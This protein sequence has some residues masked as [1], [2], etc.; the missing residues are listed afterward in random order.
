MIG[1]AQSE[2]V[3]PPRDVLDLLS[4]IV[5]R[6]PRVQCLTNSVAQTLTANVL[7]A[8]GAQVSMAQHPAEI[9]AMT[10]TADALLI[11]LGTLDLARESAIKTILGEGIRPRGPIVLDPVF[12]EC[13][14][15]RLD[16]AKRLLVLPG[17][18]IKGNAAEM[19]ALADFPASHATRVTTGAVD[20]VTGPPEKGQMSGQ[21]AHGHPLMARV[22]ATGCA[23]GALIA[24]FAAVT[25]D[26]PKAAI[27]ALTCFGL[28]GEQAARRSTGPGSFLTQLLD[29]LAG[30]AD[31]VTHKKA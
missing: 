4:L 24:A 21:V 20:H 16:L 12:A 6:R 28:A 15:L 31:H 8:V 19:T 1:K 13:S 10:R 5:A 3:L 11:N 22:T 9:A 27:A 7:L 2:F 18:I 23:A 14:P 30:Y 25:D 17:V 29:V 26:H